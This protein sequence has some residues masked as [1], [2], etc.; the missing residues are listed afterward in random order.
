MEIRNRAKIKGRERR[1][2]LVIDAGSVSE[3]EAAE[4]IES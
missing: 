1:R 4:K 2:F 3:R